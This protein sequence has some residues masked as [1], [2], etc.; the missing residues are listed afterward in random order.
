MVSSFN[1]KSIIGTVVALCLAF[2]VGCS[3]TAKAPTDNSNSTKSTNQ[4]SNSVSTATNATSNNSS[5]TNGVESTAITQPS[6]A[7]NRTK[8]PKKNSTEVVPQVNSQRIL[9]KSISTLAHQGKII[10]C[11]FSICPIE[12]VMEKWGKPDKVEGVEKAKGIYCT[13][14]RYNVVFGFGKGDLIF[15]IRSFDSR[16]RQISLSTVKN[17]LGTPA[18]NAKYYDQ[19]II[20][21][22]AGKDYKILLV[23]AETKKGNNNFM[24]DHYSVLYPA[25]TVNTMGNDQGR[26][27]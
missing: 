7:S 16:L 24:L 18:Y 2:M 11:D 25:G 23:F 8:I 9:L 1:K 27:W 21:Y 4:A 14:S 12:N 13:Y 20:G 5:S 6:V 15:E 19:K 22:T 3:S 10:N 17:T 26:Q